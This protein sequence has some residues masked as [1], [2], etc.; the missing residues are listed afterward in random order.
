MNTTTKAP[1]LQ[2]LAHVQGIAT[3]LRWGAITVGVTATLAREEMTPALAIVTGVLVLHA[4]TRMHWP[5]GN[6]D[7]FRTKLG[8]AAET[9][10]PIAILMLSGGW[11]SPFV[12]YPVA[13]LLSVGNQFGYPVA[14]ASA[15]GISSSVTAYELASR[16]QDRLAPT[17]QGWGLLLTG[18]LIGG[19]TE[20]LRVLSDQPRDL[21]QMETANDLLLQL[22]NVAQSLPASLDLGDVMS[23]ARQRF[24]ESFNY[25]SAVILVRDDATNAWK[26]ELAEGVKLPTYLA[27]ES[28]PPLLDKAIKHAGVQ[29]EN[30]VLEHGQ[31]G[32]SP[33]ARS[34][35]TIALHT[36]GSVLGIVCLEHTTAHSFQAK[37]AALLS[38]LAAP[39]TL[40]I[41]NA[42]WFGRIRTLGAEAERNRIARDIHD[43]LAQAFAYL[44]FELERLD[45]KQGGN[46]EIQQLREIVREML[47]DLRDTLYELRASVTEEQPLEDVA[48]EYLG[49]YE[50]R[51]GL[52]VT[53]AAHTDGVRLPAPVEQ[54]LWRILQ[55]AL[56]NIERHAE[57]DEVHVNWVV[58]PGKA[59]LEVRDNGRGFIPSR[60]RKE[61]FG[62]LGMRERADAIGAHLQVDSQPGVGTRVLAELET[63]Q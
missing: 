20:R 7:D 24:R 2:L 25:H 28:L 31:K 49:R 60:I 53:F 54:E 5:L 26:V 55:E 29:L 27:N 15:I 59:W 37:D 8:A 3:V 9:A 1:G 35:M 52:D 39:L 36:R 47:G 33:L 51:S 42:L 45:A 62:L 23:T 43:R 10:I 19:V 40:A 22:H 46:T 34:A 21:L 4:Y 50:K 38:D 13:S 18:A 44:A 32:L 16:T 63:P 61:R 11:N 6:P 56:T 48:R 57:A 58:G 12:L 14:F 41:D 30:D 17:I